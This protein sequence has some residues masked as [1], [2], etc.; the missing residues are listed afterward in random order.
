[1]RYADAVQRAVTQVQGRKVPPDIPGM[2]AAIAELVT[3]LQAHPELVAASVRTPLTG[4]LE[5][6]VVTLQGELL[7][8]L[9]GGPRPR[10]SWGNNAYRS[11]GASA[12]PVE[13]AEDVYEA[14]GNEF[15]DQGRI[16]RAIRLA[17]LETRL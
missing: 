8:R 12:V 1:M 10:L 16:T 13:T 11:R 2:E 15:P 6:L 14:I 9:D 17:V 7:L 3:D 4:P 5:R